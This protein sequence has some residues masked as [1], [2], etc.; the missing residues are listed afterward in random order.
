MGKFTEPAYF[1]LEHYLESLN[2]N[3]EEDL[4]SKIVD[5]WPVI[6]TDWDNKTE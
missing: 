3:I 6:F 2:Y 4:K 5:L 1:L